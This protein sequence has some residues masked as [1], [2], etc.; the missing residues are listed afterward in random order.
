MVID[1]K[2]PDFK[3]KVKAITEARPHLDVRYDNYPIPRTRA[4]L[5][6]LFFKK[7]EEKKLTL[8]DL[9]KSR[10]EWTSSEEE[11]VS[12][13]EFILKIQVK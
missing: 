9:F 13:E 2:H 8:A 11:V 6:L 7:L 5:L 12:K 10:E 4:D 1:D 3:D